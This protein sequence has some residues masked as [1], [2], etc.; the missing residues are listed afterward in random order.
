MD[1][2]LF[3]FTAIV[4]QSQL[5]LALTLLAISPRI[6]GVLI[7]G[8]KGT[9]KSTAARA[10]ARLLPSGQLR[11]LALGATADRVLGG[12]DLEATL[13]TGEPQL[14]PGLLAGC[15]GGIV[16]IDEVNLLDEHLTGLVLDAAA[17]G[18]VRIEREG[19][20]ITQP[21]EF[22]LVG[23][24]NPEEGSLRPQLLDRFGLCVDVGRPDRCGRAGGDP[25]ATAGVRRRPRWVRSQVGGTGSPAGHPAA[26]RPAAGA[27]CET[28]LPTASRDQR[29]LPGGE[30]AG[31]PS[32]SGI[33][34]VRPSA[35]SLVW[36][37]RGD[38]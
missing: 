34:Q 22:A 4:G 36:K 29:P 27:R 15:N 18:V 26:R 33:R 3:P 13:A 5:R 38:Q 1:S 8:E 10:L 14:Q 21:A 23:T 17:S 25:R 16:Y 20:S 31:A 7:R 37:K 24:M 6:G 30:R 12:L 11:T 28:G 2:Q 9:A 32:R 35:R 19:L